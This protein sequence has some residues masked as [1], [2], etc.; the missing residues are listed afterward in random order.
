[1]YYDNHGHEAQGENMRIHAVGD[2]GKVVLSIIEM[3]PGIRQ[4]ELR[5]ATGYQ[6]A[7]LRHV[8]LRLASMEKIRAE[9]ADFT[10]AYYKTGEGEAT[11]E[12]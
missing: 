6:A 1:M 5:R 11:T 8:L 10:W 7:T 9:P 12:E 4:Y 2:K 3:H